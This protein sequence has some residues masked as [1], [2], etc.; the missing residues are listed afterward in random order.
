MKSRSISYVGDEG[1]AVWINLEFHIRP[2]IRPVMKDVTE[3]EGTKGLSL[4][5]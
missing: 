1:M 5:V 3:Q 2:V 4:A